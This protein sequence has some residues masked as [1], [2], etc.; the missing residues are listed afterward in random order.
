MVQRRIGAGGMGVVYEAVDRDRD[1]V[2]ALKTLRH[3]D[4]RALYRFKA[5]FRTLADVAHPN[6]VRLGEL[7]GGGDEWFF[8]MELVEGVDFLA[9]VRGDPA[10][11]ADSGAVTAPVDRP[12]DPTPLPPGADAPL[13]PPPVDEPRLRAALRQLAEG[14]V[15]LHA[16]HKVHRDLKPSNVMVT[17]AGRVVIL[18][19]GLATDVDRV[20]LLESGATVVGTAAYMAPEQARS[21]KVGA[22]ADWYALGAM[23]YE[24]L[25]GRHPFVGSPLEVL[26]AK[27]TGEPPAVRALAPASPH[28]LAA[29]CEDLLRRDPAARPAAA[30]ILAR[31]GAAPAPARSPDDAAPF[32]GRGEELDALAAAFAEAE[33]GLPISMFVA[34][35]SGM[36]KTALVRRFLDR[37]EWERPDALILTGRCYERESVPFKAFDDVVDA[38]AGHLVRLAPEEVEALLPR[39]V[40]TLA[41][42]FPVLRRVGAIGRAPAAK[43]TDLLELRQRAFEALRALLA[44]LACTRP[45]VMFVDDFQW[46]DADSLALFAAVMHGLEAPPLLFVATVRARPDDVA[47]GRLPPALGAI[48]D[49]PGDLRTLPLGGLPP[50]D[51]WGLASQLLAGAHEPSVRAIVAEAGGHPLFIQELVRHVHERAGERREIDLDDAIWA[52][53]GGAEPTAR[54]L[55]EVTAVAGEPLVQRIAM[56][57]AGLDA[58]ELAR[59]VGVLRAA[60]LVR[61]GGGRGA[62]TVECYHDRIREAVVARLA[63]EA[64]RGHHE[65]VANALEAGASAG[66]D[67]QALVR[68]LE[69]AG[70][71]DR[72]AE[73]AIRAA[74]AAADALA[75]D[76]AAAMFGAALRLGDH[77]EA[78]ARQLRLEMAEALFD[79][80]RGADAAD[81]YLAAADG[82]DAATRFECRRK[83]AGQLLITG[84]LERGLAVLASVLAELGEALPATKR[85]A[86]AS[87]VWNRARLRL[88]GTSFTPRDESD[89]RQRDL[90][91][92]DVF[93]T[94]GVGLSFVD[95]VRGAAFQARGLRLALRV[96]EPRRVARAVALDAGFLAAQGP[97]ANARAVRR[98]ARVAE[99][100]GERADPLMR[101]W[102]IGGMGFAHYLGGRFALGAA[103]LAEAEPLLRHDTHG[104]IWE[105]NTVRMFR[106]LALRHLGRWRALRADLGDL[107]RDAARRGD[108]YAQ[109]TLSRALNLAW[110]VAGD[111]ARARRELA[112]ATWSPPEGGYHMQHWYELRARAELALYEGDREAAAALLGAPFEALAAS[113]LLHAQPIRTD[114]L[115]LRGRLALAAGGDRIAG[116]VADARRLAGE[117]VGYARAWARLLEAGIAARRGD[118]DG[119]RARLDEAAALAAEAD[120]A[121]CVAAA[122]WHLDDVRGEEAMRLEGVADPARVAAL[123][124]PGL[125]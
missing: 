10:A 27:Q 123:L 50:G 7:F 22:E 51:A 34:G 88:R 66:H 6:L 57:A 58:D 80:G 29:L 100:V 67:A 107:L 32:V 19:F 113:L 94:V 60:S 12:L 20:D 16:A 104:N 81:A 5:E 102:A 122:R 82:A 41:R 54:R 18:D 108:R 24:A 116:A 53:I 33:R 30:A 120:L 83:A 114:A 15:A 79:A 37:V 14:L 97:R 8:T 13:P 74:R 125:G 89:V 99:L 93:H 28:D 69:A 95:T 48:H 84:N 73:Q 21:L 2:V 115:W 47:A 40:G 65:R 111:P 96:G 106:M 86:V 118:G 75:F 70:L 61:T 92:I 78:V 117:G 46:A 62:E 98:M 17:P 71:A 23:L 90:V 31:L 55:L 101:G 124:V 45:V 103:M 109:T 105:L 56:Q 76:Q 63:A 119:A 110:L 42:L 59:V 121:M 85:R 36:G 11:G 112:A 3:L 72:A 52:R 4:A 26:L 77:P 68:H 35:E 38:L 39:H 64:L 9:W 25:T 91:L 49:V 87:F 43:V 1:V 44:A